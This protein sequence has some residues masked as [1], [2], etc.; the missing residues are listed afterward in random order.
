MEIDV[1]NA[2]FTGISTVFASSE[3]INIPFESILGITNLKQSSSFI[4]LDDIS[5]ISFCHCV[6]AIISISNSANVIFLHRATFHITGYEGNT[7]VLFQLEW[8]A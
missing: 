5:I 2:G 4:D 8:F 7:H 6:V 1:R 3:E